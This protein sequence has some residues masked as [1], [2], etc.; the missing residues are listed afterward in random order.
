MASKA[1]GEFDI[2]A[3]QPSRMW[4]DALRPG[5][6]HLFPLAPKDVFGGMLLT[7]RPKQGSAWSAK[8]VSR[9]AF[10]GC[11][12]LHAAKQSTRRSAGVTMRDYQAS[13]TN[14]RNDAHEASRE[15][16]AGHRHA[17]E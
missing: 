11:V 7:A 12:G 17:W 1:S 3:A 15:Q 5:G 6:R 10:I 4:L 16:A 8:F 9:A 2:S 13:V 14:L